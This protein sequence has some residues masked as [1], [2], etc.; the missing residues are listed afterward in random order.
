M[1][2]LFVA[3]WLALCLLLLHLNR[4]LALLEKGQSQMKTDLTKFSASF[5]KFA[6]DFSQFKT[7]LAAFLQALP[8]GDDPAVQVQIDG[9]ATQLDDMDTA[10]QGMDASL[11]PAA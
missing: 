6:G 7:D 10:V 9:F 5:S 1:I 3:R 4:R 8:T 11:K 2:W